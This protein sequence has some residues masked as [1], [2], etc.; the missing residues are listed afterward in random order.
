MAKGT[1]TKEAQAKLYLIIDGA[2][3]QDKYIDADE[4]KDIFRQ[5]D[6]L[7]IWEGQAEAMLNH[8]CKKKGWTRENEITYY[9][10][11]MLKEATADDG[12]IDKKEFDHIVGFAAA[13]R[14]PRK[15]AIRI[16]CKL[17]REGG[18]AIQKEGTF[19]KKDWFAD[20]EGRG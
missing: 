6:E 13:V 18:Y 19:K 10:R 8:S 16:C 11:V 2:G 9:L 4:E 17:V 15:D 3:V 14:M 12:E 20:Y 5:A 1:G 7:D